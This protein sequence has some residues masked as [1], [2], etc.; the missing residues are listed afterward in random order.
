[1]ANFAVS[2][3][4]EA[5]RKAKDVMAKYEVLGEKQED[6]LMRI[7]A[8]A[9]SVQMKETHP[10][11]KPQLEEIDATIA[12]LR[13][14][15]DGLVAGQDVLVADYRRKLEEAIRERDEAVKDA[16]AWIE[17]AQSN[18]TIMKQEAEDAFWKSEQAQARYLNAQER[19]ADKGK[20]YDLL[21]NRHAAELAAANAAAE[22]R[23]ERAVAEKERELQ[24][25][26]SRLSE[27]NARLEGRLQA[28]TN[29]RKA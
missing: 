15:I 5:L 24:A 20:Q 26:I 12:C 19:A 11:F 25:V 28:A 23:V 4:D 6:T 17:E 8:A 9:E 3:S 21:L 16:E 27:E 2:T 18:V 13:R 7:M 22:L 10:E 29:Q 1:M 14:Q